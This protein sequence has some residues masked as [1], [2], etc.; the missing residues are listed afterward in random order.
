MRSVFEG[1]A[2]IYEMKEREIQVRCGVDIR[3]HG[4]RGKGNVYVVFVGK[5]KE[6]ELKESKI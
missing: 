3:M 6:R 5:V 1:K 4:R 2:N